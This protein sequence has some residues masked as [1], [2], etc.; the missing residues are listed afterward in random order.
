MKIPIIPIFEVSQSLIIPSF[1]APKLTCHSN[2][3]VTIEAGNWAMIAVDGYELISGY[4]GGN[5]AAG[6]EC[7]SSE[8]YG[9]IHFDIQ[10]NCHGGNG[11]VGNGNTMTVSSE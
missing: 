6:S 7:V 3:N 11:E 8:P 1:L 2:F 9:D 10:D 4:Y 5:P